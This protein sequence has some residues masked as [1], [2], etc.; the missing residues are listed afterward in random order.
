[1]CD[2][3]PASDALVFFGATGDLAYKKIFPALQQLVK[4]GK[5][6]SP[7]IGVAKSGWNHDQLVDRAKKSITEY[8]GIDEE[9]FP[10][11][12]KLLRYVDGDYGDPATFAKL[13]GELEGSKRPTHYLAIPPS[14]FPIVVENLAKAGCAENARVIVEKPFGRDL[15]S[16]R[17]LNT[18]LHK[19]FPEDSIFRIDHY[20]GK[21]AVQNIL[22][23]RFANAFLE[24]IWNRHYVENVQVTMAENFGVAGRG[25]FYD[26]TG[27]IRD[28]IQNH[29]FQV[30]SYLAMEAPSSTYDEAIRDEQAKVLRNVRPLNVD[31]M[32]RGQF[33]GYRDEPG[34][35]KD[36]YMATY[37]ALRLY[38]DSWRWEGVPFYVRAGKSLNMTVTEITVELKNPPQVV[39]SEA[40]PSVG[41][42]VRFRVSPQVQI[43]IGARAK[44]PGEGM[45]GEPL[46]LS[47][48]D[49]Q[50]TQG[51]PGGRLGDYARLIGDAMSGDAT[52]FARQ[53][54]VEAAWA[55]I[56]PVI[57]GPSPMYEYDPGTWGPPQADRLVADI[58]GWNTPK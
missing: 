19:V 36:S 8:G 31:N 20:L 38:I 42:Y 12:V 29:M 54:V 10:K 28:V 21:E 50:Q 5:L 4:R 2:G 11:L 17:D 49:Q 35:S 23:F 9:A 46:E 27:V 55:I 56:D 30:I 14:L 32:V 25:K 37:A 26:E 7:V 58:G 22:Y 6:D 51:K 15:E 53:D 34:V 18:T 40:T 44:R 13:R 33:R 48:V 52:L 16:A 1:M 24:P 41:N 39:F 3:K 45:A 47:V 57:H 43:A